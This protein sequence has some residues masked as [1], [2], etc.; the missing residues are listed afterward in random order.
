M[1]FGEKEFTRKK[2]RIKFFRVILQI[3][4][5]CFLGLILANALFT[6]KSYIPYQERNDV[7]ISNDKGFIALS[8]FGVTPTGT[9]TLIAN[10]RLNEHLTALR[11]CGYVTISQQDVIDYYEQGKVLPEKALFLMCLV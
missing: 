4:I 11:D 2:N 6:F 8:Y 10:D 5:L 3:V 1:N 7:P 9:D